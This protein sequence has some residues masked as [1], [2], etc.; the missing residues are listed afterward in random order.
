MGYV[1]D[2]EDFLALQGL[3]NG[4]AGVPKA[5]PGLPNGQAYGL[6]QGQNMPPPTSMAQQRPTIH[7]QMLSYQQMLTSG[8]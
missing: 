2:S 7:Q 8:E 1:K 4:P 3:Q 5:S 6:P